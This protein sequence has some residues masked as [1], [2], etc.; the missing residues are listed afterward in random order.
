MWT[1]CAARRLLAA[2]APTVALAT[3]ALTTVA[4]TSVAR[5]SVARTS[6]ARTTVARTTPASAAPG[7][8]GAVPAAREVARAR[9]PFRGAGAVALPGGGLAVVW[10]QRGGVFARI[11][12][13]PPVALFSEGQRATAVPAEDGVLALWTTMAGLKWAR[14]I[15]LARRLD[16]H[17]A[18]LE[19]P[20]PARVGAGGNW[21]SSSA[22]A[23][24]GAALYVFS[25]YEYDDAT[26]SRLPLAVGGA[27][28]DHG[29]PR[30]PAGT[31]DPHATEVHAL[32]AGP[33][34]LE[35]LW[36]CGDEP[37]GPVRLLWTSLPAGGAATTRRLRIPGAGADGTGVYRAAPTADG[38][39]VVTARG[40]R[41][42]ALVRITRGPDGAPVVTPLGRAPGLQPGVAR[43]FRGGLLWLHAVGS[44]KARRVELVHVGPDGAPVGAPWVL[45]ERPGPP[46]DRTR[47]DANGALGGDDAV[48]TA[49]WT[50]KDGRETVLRAVR[51]TP[52]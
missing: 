46:T 25:A 50:A 41:P 51:L 45:D 35:A 5:T 23:S 49:V 13:A 17:G 8:D 42:D 14:K 18:P 43:P 26:L 20:R 47:V 1:P 15:E 4:L 34:G 40:G 6:V 9:H 36:G 31:C 27:V 22:L 10:A 38:W 24:D 7:A 52:P 28:A 33:A 12:D 32:A 11:D 29:R 39:L 44:G 16:A 30:P 19:E 3:V 21:P 2:V 48:V 37:Q